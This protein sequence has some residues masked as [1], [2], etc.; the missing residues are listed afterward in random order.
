MAAVIVS[1]EAGLIEIDCSIEEVHRYSAEVTRNPVEL[2]AA[3]TDH[4]V[5]QPASLSLN[6]IISNTPPTLLGGIAGIGKGQT[7]LELLRV[8]K[9]LGSPLTV[10]TSI[11]EYKSMILTSIEAPRSAKTG[12]AVE[13]H[14]T[15]EEVR[16]VSSQMAE[17]PATPSASKTQAAGAQPTTPAPAP[18]AAANQSVLAGWAG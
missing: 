2:G 14:L 9:E 5:Q 4:V 7:A 1:L 17:V 16:L 10:I 15:F 12:D 11:R 13:V 18:A 8:V 3:V 6:G